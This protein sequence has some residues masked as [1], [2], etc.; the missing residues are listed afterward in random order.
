LGKKGRKLSK[1]TRERMS[2]A[3]LLRYKTQPHARPNLGQKLPKEWC[4]NISK[5]LLRFYSKH[6]VWNKGLPW[7]DEVKEHISEGR[8]GQPKRKSWTWS[9]EA[10]Q[11]RSVAVKA[12]WERKKEQERG[13]DR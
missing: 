8:T 5:S 2:K 12:A 9:E 11:N 7:P 13:G 10:K 1:E 4:E 6:D 3:Q